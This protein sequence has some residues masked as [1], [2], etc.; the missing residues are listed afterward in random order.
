MIITE[1]SVLIT[2][3]YT[4][5][6]NQTDLLFVAA[7]IT[8][9]AAPRKRVF[10]QC[11]QASS[12]VFTQAFSMLF[13]FDGGRRT[14]QEVPPGASWDP[15]GNSVGAFWQPQEPSP[16]SSERLDQEP[17]G[18]LR[19]ALGAL[20]GD[21]TRRCTAPRTTTFLCCILQGF[22]VSGRPRAALRKASKGPPRPPGRL[23]RPVGSAA[24]EACSELEGRFFE[25]LRAKRP[26][27]GP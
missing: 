9:R 27:S 15:R 4:C 12:S 18:G 8:S 1:C 7:L 25:D 14:A 26:R 19:K 20:L 17:L 5:T 13:Y 22:K 6:Y 10:E 23:L 2:S 3:I 24:E 11:G 21:K 16:G